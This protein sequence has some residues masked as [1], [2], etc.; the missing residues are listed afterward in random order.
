MTSHGPHLRAPSSRDAG[1]SS[2]TRVEALDCWQTTEP[3]SAGQGRC[4]RALEYALQ[5]GHTH[6]HTYIRICP[7]HRTQLVAELLP[8]C[9]IVRCLVVEHP[10]VTA[11]GGSIATHS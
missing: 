11:L 7:T 2:Q 10:G 6:T 5:A 8:L 9:G 4:S 3:L 1:R